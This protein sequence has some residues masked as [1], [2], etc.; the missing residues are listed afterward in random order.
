LLEALFCILRYIGISNIDFR[1]KRDEENLRIF[2]P[3]KAPKDFGTMGYR[4]YKHSPKTQRLLFSPTERINTHRDIVNDYPDPR[5]YTTAKFYKDNNID[6]KIRSIID[7]D[8]ISN[9]EET[10]KGKDVY[11][12]DGMDYLGTL[13]KRKGKKD[14][15]YKL[16]RDLNSLE[17]HKLEINKIE[18]LAKEKMKINK[19]VVQE[20]QLT[21]M[22]IN[23]TDND[24]L[25]MNKIKEIRQLIR[26]RY[27]NRKNVNKIFQQW[28]RTFP[29]K[30]TVYDAY[31]MINSL[32]IPINYNETRAFI[33]SG[34][35]FG[36]EF[37]SLDEFSNLIFNKNED[38]YEDPWKVKP[39]Q[40][41]ILKEK[42]QENLK[43]KIIENNKEIDD[44][45]KL[46]TLKDFLS[47]KSIYFIKNLKEISKEKYYFTNIEYN[48]KINFSNI[49]LNKCNYDKFSKT[50]LSLKPSESF[51]KEKYIKIL[52]DEYKD[53]DNLVDVK[54]FLNDLYDKNS[55]SNNDYMSKLKD[56][57][58]EVFKE[59]VEAKKKDLKHYVSENKDKK[60]IIYKKKFDLDNHLLIKKENELKEKKENEKQI[61]D[62]NCTV[63][64]TPWIHHVFDKREEHYNILNRAEY[65]FSAKPSIKQNYAKCNTRFGANPKWRKTAEILVGNEMS[66]TYISEKERF[67]LDRDVCK[68]DKIKSAR[69]K[70]GR[71]NRIRTA[72]QKFEESN[73][74]KQFLK[75]EKNKYSQM[76]KCKR[77]YKYEELIK[78]RNILI[79]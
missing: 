8:R 40:E 16:N 18:N 55:K 76:E 77:Q 75:E 25:N 46:K 39:K 62:V 69:V 50:I 70:M 31:K 32:N 14:K 33:A 21:K 36:N 11:I 45:V 64:S 57:L 5:Y 60:G 56:N 74:A 78:N 29:N 12:G 42:E 17:D 67:N 38:L 35:N 3:W 26:R 27:G 44:N 54:F 73:Y 1:T 65:S 10:F 58:S 48:D 59:Q 43:N 52:F 4:E 2:E 15:K 9:L 41:N 53:K 24:L 61:T 34:S 6:L 30:I 7:K 47:Q 20:T 63:P 19:D 23:K 72:I 28:A 37:L 79:E 68:E 66:P 22:N 49:N 71:E 13:R 51:S